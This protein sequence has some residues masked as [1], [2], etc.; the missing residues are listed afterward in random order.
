MKTILDEIDR[1]DEEM[2]E[3]GQTLG[4]LGEDARLTRETTVNL[5]NMTR[6][7]MHNKCPSVRR[8]RDK[9]RKDLKREEGNI[10]NQHEYAQ[11]LK[12][13]E[14]ATRAEHQHTM[15]E[16]QEKLDALRAAHQA[17]LEELRAAHAARLAEIKAVMDD[18]RAQLA[19]LRAGEPHVFDLEELEAEARAKLDASGS[20]GSAA[21]LDAL[22]AELAALEAK[23]AEMEA[24][25]AALQ[26]RPEPFSRPALCG[27]HS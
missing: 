27:A 13:K 17:R 19:R 12:E 1:L 21:A 15:D 6:D 16:L 8:K 22:R 9:R 23:L 11:S 25:L 26:A 2:V 5:E 3:L 14:N 20:S 7:V 24:K 4:T 18:S 10:R